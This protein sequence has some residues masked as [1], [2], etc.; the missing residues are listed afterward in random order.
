[1]AMKNL[2]MK[3]VMIAGAAIFAASA[4]IS[5]AQEFGSLLKGAVRESITAKVNEKVPYA[6]DLKEALDKVNEMPKTWTEFSKKYISAEKIKE[7]SDGLKAVD[8]SKFP[9]DLK[10]AYA[11]VAKSAEKLYQTAEKMPDKENL[12]SKEAGLAALK[13]ALKEGTALD[14]AGEITKELKSCYGELNEARTNLVKLAIKHMK[15]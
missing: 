11:E 2:T 15:G 9:T 3:T 7:M 13:N 6:T 5:Q 14:R 10:D 4:Q 8:T 12:A 1:M